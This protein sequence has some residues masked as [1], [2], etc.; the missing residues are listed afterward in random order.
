MSPAADRSDPKPAESTEEQPTEPPE[1]FVDLE[2]R[3]TGEWTVIPWVRPATAALLFGL[4][5]ALGGHA[6]RRD[7]STLSVLG[8]EAGTL[9]WLYGTTVLSEVYRRGCRLVVVSLSLRG[10]RRPQRAP[11]PN[12]GRVD[13]CHSTRT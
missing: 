13:Q 8:I 1:S 10:I 12:L 11:D 9:A 3:S 6:S 4:L 5:V 2:L 7:L